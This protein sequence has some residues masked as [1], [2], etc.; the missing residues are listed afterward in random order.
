MTPK[1]GEKSIV[2][3]LFFFG[4]RHQEKKNADLELKESGIFIT[5]KPRVSIHQ[6]NEKSGQMK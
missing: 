1:V 2:N 3:N 4:K 6:P 5:Q